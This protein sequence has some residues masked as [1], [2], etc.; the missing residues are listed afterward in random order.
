MVASVVYVFMA[1]VKWGHWDAG[2]DFPVSLKAAMFVFIFFMLYIIIFY[3][4]LK[5]MMYNSVIM[6]CS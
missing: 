4:K 5:L 1:Q 2:L 3:V 6:S